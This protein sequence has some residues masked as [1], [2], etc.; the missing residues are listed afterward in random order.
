MTIKHLHHIGK[1]TLPWLI[2]SLALVALLAQPQPSQAAVGDLVFTISAPLSQESTVTCTN[3]F[4]VETFNG[5]TVADYALLSGSIGQY[6][7]PNNAA[8]SIRIFAQAPT[9]GAQ[10]PSLPTNFIS[11]PSSYLLTLDQPAGYFGFWWSAGDG[12]N[13]VTVNMSDGSSQVFTTQSIL[14]SGAVL[15]SP[16]S[17]QNGHYGN[18]TTAFSGQLDTELF[19]FVNIFATNPNAK[20]ESL[21]FEQVQGAGGEFESDNHTVCADILNPDTGTPIP[22]EGSITIVKE[23][24][25]ESDQPFVFFTNIGGAGSSFT[26]VDNGSSS[27]S[28]TF[29]N[30]PPAEYDVT[31]QQNILPTG[32]NLDSIVCSGG[33]DIT[34]VEASAN[35]QIR[36]SGGEDVICTFNNSNST[37]VVTLGWFLA[38]R[39]GDRVDFRWQTA[40]ESGVAGFNMLAVT[41][42]G[43]VQLNEALIPSTVI[44]SVTPTDYAFSAATDAT[45]FVLQEVEISGAITNHGPFTIGVESGA[46]NEVDDADSHK[47]WLPLMMR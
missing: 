39:D 33:N 34:I 14:D 6:T 47:I 16:G 28:T 9:G 2:V 38:E 26:L 43:T 21:L 25:P 19:A 3:G 35:V 40:T 46:Y 17:G 22:Q 30:L 29:S 4:G 23:A 8:P 31:E 15:G 36:L 32:W 42:N 1:R 45:S 13:K 5:I 11:T 18:P 27:N 41:D 37:L 20:I 10:F 12:N 24:T 44:D 7:D